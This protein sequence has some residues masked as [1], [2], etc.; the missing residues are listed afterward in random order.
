MSAMARLN[1]VLAL[2]AVALLAY[3]L[4]PRQDTYRPLTD[5]TASQINQIRQIS[6]ISPGQHIELQKKPHGWE[7]ASNLNADLNG[8]LAGDSGPQADTAVDAGKVEQLLGLTATHSYRRFS[9]S[10]DNLQQ[11]GLQNDQ[12]YIAFDDL[13]IVYGTT[14]PVDDLRYVLVNDSIHLIKDL[15]LKF[16]LADAAFFAAADSDQ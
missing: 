14:E 16:L 4:W 6:I 8:D 11:F 5:L 9:P 12:R 2:L 3:Q 15:Y 13:K 7:L 1:I 10:A